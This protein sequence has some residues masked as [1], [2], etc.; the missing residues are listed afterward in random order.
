MVLFVLLLTKL[1]AQ[2]FV[3]LAPPRSE[4]DDEPTDEDEVDQLKNK[5]DVRLPRHLLLELRDRPSEK[6]VPH[7]AHGENRVARQDLVPPQHRVALA[8]DRGLGLLVARR[9]LEQAHDESEDHRHE[10]FV[11]PPVV[12]PCHQGDHHIHE[13]PHEDH[14][15]ATGDQLQEVRLEAESPGV[16]ARWPQDPDDAGAD[17]AAEHSVTAPC[18]ELLSSGELLRHALGSIDIHEDQDDF[19]DHVRRDP[20]HGGGKTACG[21]RL[22]GRLSV[23]LLRTV[24][25]HAVVGLL[26]QLIDPQ[27]QRLQLRHVRL[28]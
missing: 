7:L 13:T 27:P 6:V 9:V 15:C 17:E 11:P 21:E 16:G 28:L 19:I 23:G 18:K 20:G 10:E 22:H 24:E 12:C 26:L 14:G 8:F 3:L 4:E 2:R 1:L 25:A 5:V